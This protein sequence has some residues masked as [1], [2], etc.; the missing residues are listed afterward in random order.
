MDK[1]NVVTFRSTAHVLGV[2][3]RTAQT[4]PMT[5]QHVAASGV[6]VRDSQNDGVQALV[7]AEQLQ[8]VQVDYDTRVFYRPQLFVVVGGRAEQQDDGV[9]TVSLNGTTV[10]VAL[11]AP[12]GSL[13]EA[14]V[15]VSGGALTEPIVRA[16]QIA[17]GGNSGQASLILGT[18]D[19]NVIAFAPGYA[20]VIASEP[21]P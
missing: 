6:L 9:V 18:G 20:S 5:V 14:F 13:I 12:A 21:V 16:V 7:D 1:M 17:S 3:V 11:P 19:Y 2:A 10:T 4:D 15:H 8:V